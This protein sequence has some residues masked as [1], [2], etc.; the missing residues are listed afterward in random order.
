M[1]DEIVK[2][3]KDGDIVDES[4][5]DISLNPSDWGVAPEIIEPIHHLI[6]C[7]V[8][9]GLDR[10]TIA[11]IFN[12]S[13]HHID[14]LVKE[15]VPELVTPKRVKAVGG[16]IDYFLDTSKVVTGEIKGSDALT[17]AKM[18]ADRSHPVKRSED[19]VVNNTFTQCDVQVLQ[20]I[21]GV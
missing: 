20:K 21:V 10:R 16:V 14:T 11:Q 5:I 13:L 12:R 2:F 7:A 6:K 19:V 18:I 3:D 1:S 9:M 17:A 4:D 15:S 8:D